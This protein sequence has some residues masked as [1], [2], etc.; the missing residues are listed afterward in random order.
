MAKPIQTISGDVIQLRNISVSGGDLPKD[1]KVLLNIDI[2][3]TGVSRQQL[4][5]ACG[6]GQSL[7][8]KA[9]RIYRAKPAS[10][11]KA[12]SVSQKVIKLTFKDIETHQQ[13]VGDK[14]MLMTREQFIDFCVNEV[15]LDV[16]GGHEVYNKK[17]GLPKGDR[18]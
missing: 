14:L 18:S 16:D 4:L 11:L 13:S 3:C 10:A 9:Q 5:S 2:D 6:E 7:R 15:G 1:F 12:F 8:V 17:H